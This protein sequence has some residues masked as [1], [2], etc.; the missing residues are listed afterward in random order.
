MELTVL[1][2]TSN[3][4]D[5]FFENKV[6]ETIIQNKGGLPV[7]SVSQKHM[8]FGYNICV[9]TQDN[10]YHNEFRQIQLGLLAVKTPYVIIAEAD[11]LYPPDYFA[12]RPP[13][14]GHAYM[15]DNVWVH[16]TRFNGKPKFWF[17]KN[18]DCAQVI[19]RSM[20]LEKI[21]KV[22]DSTP[23][24]TSKENKESYRIQYRANG[25][26]MWNGNPVV[27]FKTLNGVKSNTATKR[28][29]PPRY[30]LPYWGS[31]IE[32]RKQMFT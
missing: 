31:A 9:G 5:E 7:V 22:L 18:S 25:A 1:Y 6:V 29:V 4:E 10:C 23:K 30:S 8:N 28:G 15:Y 3:R 2:Y 14:R 17:K 20:W 27:T 26:C 11:T 19:D 32:L 21:N 13:E 16:Y 12:F 24:W